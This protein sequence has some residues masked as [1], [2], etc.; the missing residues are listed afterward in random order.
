ML[1]RETPKGWIALRGGYQQ[2][3]VSER[4]LREEYDLLLPGGQIK[5]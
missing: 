2:W 1:L 5:G 4:A 3:A